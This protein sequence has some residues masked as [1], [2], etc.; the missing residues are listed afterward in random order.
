MVNTATK[1]FLKKNEW[2]K[3]IKRVVGSCI[4]AKLLM[5]PELQG[6]NSVIYK[7]HIKARGRVFI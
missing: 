4:K 7:L 3:N 5:M 1:I 6:N 2:H